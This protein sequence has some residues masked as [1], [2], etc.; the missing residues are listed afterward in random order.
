MND[1][2]PHLPEEASSEAALNDWQTPELQKLPVSETA[3]RRKLI[4]T[5]GLELS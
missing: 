4:D 5:E 2:S 3:D 1:L